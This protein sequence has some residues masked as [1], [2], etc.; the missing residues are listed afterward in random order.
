MGE[1]LMEGYVYYV[2]CGVYESFGDFKR[3]IICS[4]IFF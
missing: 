4:K 1:K 2:F 3:V